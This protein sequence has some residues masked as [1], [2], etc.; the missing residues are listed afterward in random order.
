M[1]LCGTTYIVYE[2]NLG[3]VS[4]K[5]PQSQS[6]SYVDVNLKDNINKIGYL[7]LSTI[8]YTYELS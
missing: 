3:H 2:Q 4:L 1:F 6:M 8:I 7:F 5:D